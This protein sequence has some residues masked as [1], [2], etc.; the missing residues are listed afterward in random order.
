MTQK[1]LRNQQLLKEANERTAHFFT[2]RHFLKES[3][4]GFGALALGG[5]N[6]ESDP[7]KQAIADAASAEVDD[8]V[9][10]LLDRLAERL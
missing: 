10:P 4:M 9:L 6:F 7:D 8:R 5:S 3:A 1:E 2:R